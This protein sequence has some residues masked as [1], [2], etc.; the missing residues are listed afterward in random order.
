MSKQD[1]Q[2]ARTPSELE[3]K[4]AS[5]QTMSELESATKKQG[6]QLS[7]QSQAMTQFKYDSDGKFQSLE[8]GLNRAEKNIS[9]LKTS[10]SSMS[11]RM[12]AA[13]Q[14]DKDLDRKVSALLKSASSLEQNSSGANKKIATLEKTVA[15]LTKQLKTAED[16]LADLVE[17]VTA[18]E[19]T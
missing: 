18:L 5:W 19:S 15:D 2:R 11:T 3:Q 6:E 12:S 4:Y 16:T 14:K 13:E 7:L 17:R 1:R 9:A 10:D 8:A